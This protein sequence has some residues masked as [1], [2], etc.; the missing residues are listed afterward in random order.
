M[1]IYV[2]MNRDRGQSLREGVWSKQSVL[3][4][5]QL[6]GQTASTSWNCPS[7]TL[8]TDRDSSQENWGAVSRIRKVGMLG[9]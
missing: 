3:A 2:R 5:V 4:S 6:T 8:R 9:I 7:S 1:L